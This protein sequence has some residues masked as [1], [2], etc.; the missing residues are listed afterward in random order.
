M[1]D[2][3]GYLPLCSNSYIWFRGFKKREVVLGGLLRY[4][5]CVW[6]LCMAAQLFGTV[7]PGFGCLSIEVSCPFSLGASVPRMS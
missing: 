3:K 7:R 5:S 6:F 1:R 4:F 2:F